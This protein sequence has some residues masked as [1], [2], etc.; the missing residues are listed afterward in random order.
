MLEILKKTPHDKQVLG[1]NDFDYVLVN[2]SAQFIP[3]N[4]GDDVAGLPDDCLHD[5][6]YAGVLHDILLVFLLVED[7]T[8][9]D[10]QRKRD[11]GLITKLVK[12]P[13]L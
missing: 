3:S 5:A 8:Q 1:I 12:N 7:N 4:I 6:P 9:V 11:E 13:T 2:I 10:L